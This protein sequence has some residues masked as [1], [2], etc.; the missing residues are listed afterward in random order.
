MKISSL[1][2]LLLPVAL[3]AADA[4]I[5]FERRYPD[6]RGIL[7]HHWE[8]DAWAFFHRTTFDAGK[9][10]GVLLLE[11]DP[12]EKWGDLT[13]GGLQW[14]QGTTLQSVSAGFLRLG[15]ALGL[16][17][18]YGGIG[19]GGDP[20]SLVKAPVHRSVLA[21]AESAGDCDGAPLTGA[22]AVLRTRGLSFTVMQ[23]VSSVDR[24]VTGL[25]RSQTEIDG[26]GAV[27][28]VF[29]YARVSGTVIGLSGA[30][31]RTSDDSAVVTGRAGFDVRLSGDDREL[32]GEASMG[33]NDGAVPVAFLVG[34]YG[35]AGAF[36]HS[37]TAGRYPSSFPSVR[38]SV[39]FGVSHDLAGGYGVRYRPGRRVTVTAGLEVLDRDNGITTEA[40]LQFDEAPFSGTTLTQKATFAR[41]AG[42]TTLRGLLA[43]GWSPSRSTTLTL[44][45]PTASF[46]EGDS[47]SFG[48]GVEFRLKHQFR[49]WLEATFSAAGADTD[50]YPSR[51]YIY[52]LS[53]PGEFG[54][55]AMYG[56]CAVL[57]ASVSVVLG[58]DWRVRGRISRFHGYDR[59]SLGSGY[60][61]TQ[62]PTRTEAGL[63]LDWNP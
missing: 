38:S 41:T 6:P 35:D 57:Q 48:A 31:V 27:R 24:S 55:S 22:A 7:E 5:R 58:E 46:R 59:E 33:F 8:G 28:E 51:V 2:V 50:G 52:K 3:A 44:R 43:A 62:G 49:P 29:S 10:S 56:S 36:R 53:F 13:A 60:E 26:H 40:G 14:V 39:P 12:G 47:T 1:L 37:L 63:Q 11:K 42:G 45:F 23:A 18:G 9:L 32:T 34:M 30:F 4:R 54:S 16:T 19:Q 17:A 15:M 25:H 61:E 20:L 21:P